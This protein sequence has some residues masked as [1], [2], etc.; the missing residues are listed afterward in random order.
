MTIY[1]GFTVEIIGPVE[2]ISG[3]YIRRV[4]IVEPTHMLNGF[5]FNA[6]C[7]FNGELI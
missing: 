4:M 5:V 2:R 6:V 3:G 1:N 7:R